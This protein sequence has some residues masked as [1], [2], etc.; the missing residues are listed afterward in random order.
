VACELSLAVDLGQRITGT[1]I[2]FNQIA[3]LFVRPPLHFVV[4]RRAIKWQCLPSGHPATPNR[5]SWT[6]P[7]QGNSVF[8]KRFMDSSREKG[9]SSDKV[10][11][12]ELL[13]KLHL[14]SNPET[15]CLVRAT[16]ERATELLHFQA[17]DSRAIVR[18]VDEAL[19][20]VMRHAYQGQS[21]L[22]IELTC[23]KLCEHGGAAGDSVAGMEILLED[24][25]L[26]PDPVKFKGRDLEDIRPGGLGLHFMRQSMDRVEFSREKGK[27]HLRMVKYLVPAARLNKPEGE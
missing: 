7:G 19:A 10:T 2:G 5:A 13:L 1:G 6:S 12:S 8:A 23:W 22:P 11:A 20:N 4:V 17:E 14:Q 9:I 26:A 21:G 24:S 15:L 27:N 3:C 16:L 25:G 18:S